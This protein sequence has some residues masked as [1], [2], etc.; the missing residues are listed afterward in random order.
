[1]SQL[2]LIGYINILIGVL[3]I[4]LG[5][6]VFKQKKKDRLNIAYFFSTLTMGLWSFA[7]YFYSNP[8]IF[9]TEVWLKIVYVLAYLMTLGQLN[10]VHKYGGGTLKKNLKTLLYILMLFF[11]YG[12]YLLLVKDSVV[13]S[14][15]NN[16]EY[17]K[18]VAVMGADYWLYFLP[19]ILT[20]VFMFSSLIKEGFQS[21]G[22][23]STQMKLYWVGGFLMIAPLLLLDFVLPVFYEVTDLYRY[24]ALGNIL[25]AIIIGYSIISTRFLDVRVVVGKAMS[26]L[27]RT[28]NILILLS[29][30]IYIIV[31]RVND[32]SSLKTFVFISFLAFVFTLILEVGNRWSDDYIRRKFVYTHY[33]PMDEIQDYS[34][35]VSELVS[36]EAIIRKTSQLFMET[37]R[38]IGVGIILYKEREGDFYSRDIVN[39]NIPDREDIADFSRQWSSLNSN[40]VLVYS[41]MKE[42]VSSGKEIIDDKKRS[43]KKFME[44]YKI[45][46]V[47]PVENNSGISGVVIFSEKKDNSAYSVG[48]ISFVESIVG[49]MGI[50]I[51]RSFLFDELQSF[52]RTL[53]SKVNEQ[54]KE[55][56]TKVSELQ[57]ARRKEADMIDIMGHELRTPATIVKLNAELL[58]GI[59]EKRSLID[60]GK[61]VVRIQEGVEREIKLINTLLSSAK[62]EGDKIELNPEEVNIAN[63]IEVSL[64]AHEKD[65]K[66][67]GLQFNN[68]VSKDIPSVYGDHARVVEVVNNLISNAV[69]YT[70]QGSI[71][72]SAQDIGSHVQIDVK[73]TGQ[74]ISE[75]DL[76]KLGTKF[77]RVQTYIE[78]DASDDVDIVR[79]GGTGLGLYVVFNL[80]E[81]MGGKITVDSKVN[82]G[83]TFSFTLPKYINQDNRADKVKS[84]NMFERL[85][86]KK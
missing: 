5:F 14:A 83:S 15:T 22:V 1:M 26:L 4:I 76:K 21:K 66:A 27:F 62:L 23:R 6:L 33:N 31:P 86:L 36:T 58:K 85:G 60:L 52:N 39:I 63:E 53:K 10:F 11:V 71:T 47:V 24:S 48:D 75:K 61:Y 54:T 25:W 20:V 16:P 46:M 77:Y 56:Q 2:D 13:L 80:V 81:K 64:H 84:N 37:V 17:F 34:K 8:I 51:G 79:P 70:Q 35:M 49:S 19:I 74:G 32:V 50:A 73:D 3:D 18:S 68:L 45:E 78:S 65:A 57:E 69:K 43:I 82:E 59:I 67:K 40:P 55:L 38:P 42:F 29:L 72:I 41:E 28:F 30:F 12:L 7:L 44:E 9:D